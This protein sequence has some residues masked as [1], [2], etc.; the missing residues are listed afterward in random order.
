[1]KKIITLL[2]IILCTLLLIP[3]SVCAH[4]QV[5]VADREVI[6]GGALFGARMQTDGALVVGLD[7]VS[8]QGNS[9]PKSPAYDGGMRLKDIIIEINGKTVVSGKTVAEEI[10]GCNGSEITVKVK[11]NG[12]EKMLR[13]SPIKDK[14]GKYKAGIWI[15]DEASGI[16]TITYII[17]ETGEFAGLGHGICD[18]DTG[19]LLPIKRGVVSDAELLGVIK[20][21]SGS[22][23]EL[24]GAIGLAKKGA[25][26]KNTECGVY[27]IFAHIPD[28][29]STRI[30]VAGKNEITEGKATLRCSVSGT[31]EDYEITVSR[32]NNLDNGPK[33][34]LI[35]VTDPRLIELTGGIV[36]GLSGSP[37]IQNGKLVGAVTHVKIAE[38]TEGYGI[39]IENMLNAA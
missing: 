25:L 6:V 15:R 19:A 33:N 26:I 24:K 20:G 21:K 35:T 10:N 3:S 37:I 23:G 32:I 30:K 14:E 39:F 4:A 7:K 2:C 22:P 27:G 9:T 1:M 5:A 16:G 18:G 28:S 31:V 8:P 12:I 29:L 13:I 38:P 11:R 36:Q 17:P 34:F